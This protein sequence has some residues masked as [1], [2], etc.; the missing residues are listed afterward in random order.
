MEWP[1]EKKKTRVFFV[2]FCGGWEEFLEMLGKYGGNHQNSQ[3]W[4]SSPTLAWSKRRS[5][6]H[7]VS[8]SQGG[9]E[10]FLLLFWKSWHCPKQKQVSV[11]LRTKVCC[12]SLMRGNS[13]DWIA[14]KLSFVWNAFGKCFRSKKK[15]KCYNISTSYLQH[16]IYPFPKL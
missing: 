4:S 2:C 9:P 3:L 8:R 16:F 13:N 6:Q 14:V 1:V 12:L 10:S 11:H 5:G 15:K 7:Q